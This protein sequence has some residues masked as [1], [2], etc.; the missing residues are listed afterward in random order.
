MWKVY[1]ERLDGFANE[2]IP[3]QSIPGDNTSWRW[4]GEPV[5]FSTTIGHYGVPGY[6]GSIMPPP[7]SVASGLVAPLTDQDKRTLSRW[8]DLGTPIDLTADKQSGWF[9]DEQRPTLTVTYPTPGRN[10]ALTRIVIGAYDVGSGLNMDSLAVTLDIK[11]DGVGRNKNAARKFKPIASGVWEWAFAA[12][13]P[14]TAGA[15]ITVSIAD[16]QGNI[17]SLV[18][19][20]SV[21]SGASPTATSSEDASR[22]RSSGTVPKVAARDRQ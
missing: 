19:T 4:K 8:I 13:M 14:S 1:G 10:E 2:D 22:M 12:P 21:E 20:F 17:T 15:T 3:Y 18:R 9:P 11:V 7:E 5:A 16:V 6:T